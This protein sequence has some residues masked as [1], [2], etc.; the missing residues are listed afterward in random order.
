VTGSTYVG[1]QACSGCHANGSKEPWS[2][3]NT[4]QKTAHA[5]LFKDGVN[6]VASD[7]Y[8]NSCIACHTVGYDTNPASVNG[9][10]DDVAAKLNWTVPPVDKQKPGTF[11]SLPPE[12]QAVGNIQCENCHG[13]GSTHIKS[14]GDPL[15]ITKSMESGACG[16]CHA[17]LTHHSKTGEWLNSGHANAVNESGAGREGCVGCH[18]GM[19]FIDRVQGAQ[20][21]R[22]AYSSINCQACH[23]PH[24]QTSPADGHMLLRTV[25]PVTLKD[26]TV[27]T[28]AGKGL[29]CINCHQSRQNAK[30][31]AETSAASSRFGPHHGT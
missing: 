26:N 7:H 31:Y 13:P 20:T 23:E 5:S 9:G 18:T 29:L 19:G 10:F 21:L 12:L 8:S 17:A 22:T 2:M 4:W 1:A 24:G 6:G 11:E 15:L 30:T 3:Y 16:Q 27:I 25:D 14:G 28:D